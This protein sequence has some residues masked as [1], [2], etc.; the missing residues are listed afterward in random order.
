MKARARLAW[1]ALLGA[2]SLT[3][4]SAE[5]RTDTYTVE[6]PRYGNIGTYVHTVDVD[7]DGVTRIASRLHI[8]IR[9]LGIVLYRKDV[10][11]DEVL[12]GARLV[13]FHNMTSTN[14]HRIDVRGESR[15][16]HFVVTSPSGTMVAP[17]DV[18]PFDLWSLG[19]LG[20]GPAIKSGKLDTIRVTGGET[21]RV[22][23]EAK[24]TRARHFH[25]L[26][27]TQPNTWDVWLDEQ[28]VPIRFRCVEAGTAIDF[29]LTP[30][31]DTTAAAPNQLGSAYVAN[32][33]RVR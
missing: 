25:V 11:Q 22:S 30:S 31:S 10:D 24:T 23:R 6:H 8:A 9:K 14:G 27:G 18:A 3:A 16:N 19:Q 29:I 33:Q 1:A 13:S 2:L 17:G 15:D 4:A 21:V 32:E 26:T 20:T 7:A 5:A 12:H 28:G